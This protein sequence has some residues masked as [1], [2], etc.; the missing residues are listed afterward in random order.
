M[1]DYALRG[2][3][4]EMAEAAVAADTTLRLVRGWYHCPIW[5]DWQQHWWAVYPDSTIVDPTAAQFPSRGAGVYQEYDGLFP[6]EECGEMVHE[7]KAYFDGH[8]GFCNSE[9]FA[10]MIG[11]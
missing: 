11:F 3:C 5:G 9:C 2:K 6:C 1:S 4:K 10:R 7:Q 8:H